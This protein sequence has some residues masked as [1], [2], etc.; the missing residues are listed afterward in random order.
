MNG[1]IDH[2]EP[3]SSTLHAIKKNAIININEVRDEY[4]YLNRIK[5]RERER[6]K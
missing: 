4:K 5:Q 1:P 3:I 6:G 2:V